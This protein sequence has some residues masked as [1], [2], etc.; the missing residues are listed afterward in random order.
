M[1]SSHNKLLSFI[2]FNIQA[3]FS[4]SIQ[5]LVKVPSKSAKICI[6]A[7]HHFIN[8]FFIAS[9]LV[10]SAKYTPGHPL[11]I[12]QIN[13][14]CIFFIIIFLSSHYKCLYLIYKLLFL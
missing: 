4:Q 6:L 3:F 8:F 7:D 10:L 11:L 5:V 2:A 14:P 9:K 13:S 1:N 12:F